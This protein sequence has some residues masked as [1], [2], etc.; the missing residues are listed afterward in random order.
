MVVD[1]DQG[2]LGFTSRYLTRR[3]YAVTACRAG[4]EAWNQFGAPGAEFSVAIVDLSLKGLTG[5]E[6]S[7]RI[8]EHDREARIVLT[9]GYP[10]DPNALPAAGAGR[11]AFLH[12]PFTPA[13]LVEAIE[14]LLRK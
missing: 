5:A 13:M 12:K 1:D 2:L 6:L 8:L 7:R 9:S 14:G 3:G 4:E 10:M 11:I